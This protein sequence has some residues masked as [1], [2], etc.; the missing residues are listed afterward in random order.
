MKKLFSAAVF[1][2]FSFSVFS[3]GSTNL[4][5]FFFNVVNEDFNFPLIGI[6]N[7]ATG[8]H[9]NPQIGFINTNVGEFS[10]GQIGFINSVSS[11]TV[12]A[13]VGFINTIRGN[14]VGAQV[15]FVNTVSANE[16]GCQINTSAGNVLGLQ[17]GFVNTAKKDVSGMQA[18]FVNTALNEVEGAQIGFVNTAVNGNYGPQIG[19]VNITRR[20]NGF[21]LGFVNIV[22]TL[23]RGVPIGFLSIVRNGGFRAVEVGVSEFHLVNAGFKIGVEQF[24]TTFIAAYNPFADTRSSQT[25]FGLGIGSIIPINDS[26]FFNPEIISLT[27][28]NKNM[29]NSRRLTSFVPYF[30]YDINPQFSIV[31]A[32]TLTWS[33]REANGQL[34]FLEPLFSLAHFELNCR[35]ELVIGARVSARWR[36]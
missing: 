13:Q 18:G 31:A 28:I 10:S 9:N 19:F 22:D 30:G 12:G 33:Q 24:Y 17:L 8:S 27:T 32:P 1:C 21:Q 15:G 29:R 26:F 14:L 3:Q 2:L 6:V 5:T 23:E 36:F 34:D 16:S 25:A 7:N 11:N 35:H 4:Y 20:L